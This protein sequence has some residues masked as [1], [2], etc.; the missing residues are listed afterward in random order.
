MK[1]IA[2]VGSNWRDLDD[3]KKSIVQSRLVGADAVKFQLFTPGEL[4]GPQHGYEISQ[5][6]L[7]HNWLPILKEKCDQVGIQFMCS[8]FS[9]E[10][11]A[12]VDPYVATHKVASSECCHLRILEKLRELGKPVILSTGAKG[13][14]DIRMALQVLTG[15]DEYCRIHGLEL[16]PVPVTLMYCVVAYPANEVNLD[17]IKTLR[18]QFH[19]DVGYSD[20][21]TDVCNI[22]RLAVDKGATVIEKH[23]TIIPEVSTPDQPHSLSPDQ[24]RN[25]VKSIRGELP[26]VIGPTPQER[27][28]LLRYNRRLIAIKDLNPGDTLIEG[29]NFG[30]FRS[31]KDDTRAAHPFLVDQFIGKTAKVSLKAGDGLWIEDVE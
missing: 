19:C 15:T 26:A 18:D 10:G 27:T 13:K 24:F 20:H 22:P 12:E 23:F 14:D 7:P 30:I 8:A 6:S 16:D 25:M 17:T 11:Y 3:C 21:T 9:P 4:Y 1:I 28:A 29:E 5:Y 2:E 31:L